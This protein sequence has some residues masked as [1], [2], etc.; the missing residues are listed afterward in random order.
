V[1]GDL[2]SP[3]DVRRFVGEVTEALGRID[4]LVNNAAL[5][6]PPEHPRSPAEP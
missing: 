3:Q 1:Q 2:A 4:V 5:F 6:R